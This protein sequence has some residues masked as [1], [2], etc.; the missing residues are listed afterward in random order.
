M[1]KCRTAGNSNCKVEVAKCSDVRATTPT[2]VAKAPEKK[3]P[4]P[5]FEPKCGT[6][7]ESEWCW[8]EV[9]NKPG[10]HMRWTWGN[11]S[12]GDSSYGSG[13]TW[14]GSCSHGIANGQGTITIGWG[15]AKHE[16][17]GVLS[18]GYPDGSWTFIFEAGEDKK[19]T[20]GSYSE[21]LRHGQW[22]IHETTSTHRNDGQGSYV[23]G[24]KH[25]TWEHKSKSSIAC[26]VSVFEYSHG[27][28]DGYQRPPEEC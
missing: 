13:V 15:V 12:Y 7:G 3:E 27:A 14:T 18:N 21:G 24:K 2:E 20:K 1:L 28:W 9:S 19:I 11:W 16:G 4:V 8:L 6:G 22:T 26:V 5:A 23:R 25:G 17:T 10:C